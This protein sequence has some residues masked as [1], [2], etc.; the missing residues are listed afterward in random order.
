VRPGRDDLVAGTPRVIAA[1]SVDAHFLRILGASKYSGFR[2]VGGRLA[3]EAAA[4]IAPRLV[5]GVLV[6][7]PITRSRRRERGFNQTEDLAAAIAAAAG[8]SVE[9]WL[10]RTRGGRALAGRERSTREAIVR[11]AFAVARSFPGEGGGPL[12]LVDDVVTTGSTAAACAA[13]LLARGGVP[14]A[15]ASMGRAFAPL[16]DQP[17]AGDSVLERL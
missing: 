8:L 4:R 5:P 7:V 12:I 14:V 15:V 3:R 1:F 17:L 13:A 9:K 2:A 10:V 6:P 16:E 11:G